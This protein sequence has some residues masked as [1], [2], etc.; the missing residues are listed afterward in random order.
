MFT[1]LIL[2]FLFFLILFIFTSPRISP[3]P[4]FPTNKKDLPLIIK[5]F[6]LQN[7]QVVVDLGAG[8][9]VVIF[10]AANNTYQK[11]LNTQ[12]I[13]VEINPVLIL[14][15]HLR[16]LIH[17]NKKNIKIIWADLF[18]INFK[19]LLTFNFHTDG[20][21]SSFKVKF[22]TFY[23][24]VSPWL[25]E[26]IISNIQYPISN[27]SFVSYMYPIKSLKKKEKRIKGLRHDIFVYN[28][29]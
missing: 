12:F 8:D 4:Y 14:I 27:I 2:I 11:N 6:N 19:K 16:R 13:A 10:A 17:P 25:L 5:A 15:M 26:K 1:F 24:Y 7:N 21:L 28:N 23:L 29:V 18:K 9:G 20:N 3:I 22:L